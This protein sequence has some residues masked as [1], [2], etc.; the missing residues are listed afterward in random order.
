ME[1]VNWRNPCQSMVPLKEYSI[2]PFS[3]LTNMTS[4]EASGHAGHAEHD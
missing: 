2:E 3:K 1:K 4:G